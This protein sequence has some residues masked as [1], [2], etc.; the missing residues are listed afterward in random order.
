MHLREKCDMC[1]WSTYVCKF[2]AAKREFAAFY[3]YCFLKYN[4]WFIICNIFYNNGLIEPGSLN[5]GR[6]DTFL[7]IAN[8]HK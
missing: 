7:I 4:T 5:L 6:I 3:L 8:W 2:G 1:S